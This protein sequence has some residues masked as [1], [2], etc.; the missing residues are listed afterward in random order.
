[1]KTP[2]FLNFLES[3]TLSS[4]SPE[5]PSSGLR[6]ADTRI[7]LP[8]PLFPA[9]WLWHSTRRACLCWRPRHPTGMVRA[10][11]P[12][13]RSIQCPLV[14]QWRQSTLSP[15]TSKTTALQG[16]SRE[17][18]VA[19]PCECLFMKCCLRTASLEQVYVL[20]SVYL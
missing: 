10:E 11:C 18:K 7:W 14:G 15:N 16:R 6:Q 1:M 12:F 5:Y 20:T 17:P 2:P 4:S 19:D 3:A 13:Y 9:S 8:L